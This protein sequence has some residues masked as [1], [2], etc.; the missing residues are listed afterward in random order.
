MVR[1]AIAILS[2]CASM[3]G[4]CFAQGP[5]SLAHP[6][7]PRVGV[8]TGWQSPGASTGGRGSPLAKLTRKPEVLLKASDVPDVVLPKGAPKALQDA[9]DKDVE[10]VRHDL[11][12]K[13]V[14]AKIFEVPEGAVLIHEAAGQSVYRTKE[15]NYLTISSTSSFGV[16]DPGV[17]V[18]QAVAGSVLSRGRSD[19]PGSEPRVRREDPLPTGTLE[20]ADYWMV[21]GRSDDAIKLFEEHLATQPD[22]DG[23]NIRMGLALIESGRVA[24]GNELIHSIYAANP[25]LASVSLEDTLARWGAS[26]VRMMVSRAV[27]LANHTGGAAD[28]MVVAVLMEAEGRYE[29][30]ARM[31][32]RAKSAGLGADLWAR[33][34]AMIHAPAS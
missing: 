2:V 20:R 14:R 33:L 19:R 8:G 3:P 17:M 16:V 13:E 9:I 21:N 31:L 10:A 1:G 12:M 27:T 18:Y 4:A 22:D 28:W 24:S 30:A 6:D 23:A 34:D 5:A 11:E 32:E 29:L 7:V 25:A 15:G 26:R